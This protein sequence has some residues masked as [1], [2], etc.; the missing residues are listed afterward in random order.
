MGNS[1]D[2]DGSRCSARNRAGKPCRSPRVNGSRDCV[3][4]DP[5]S[6]AKLA[7]A[8]RR[9]GHNSR[10]QPPV[11]ELAE[12]S[13]DNAHDLILIVAEAI[14]LLRRNEMDQKRATAI[15]YLV[16]IAL[17]VRDATD[18]DER[19]ARLEALLERGATPTEVRS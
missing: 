7:E 14:N 3:F 2:L 10:L 12:V 9:G 17:K 18:T 19:L 8:R 11:I 13:L 4:H 5:A 15:G 16:G 1:K 6:A